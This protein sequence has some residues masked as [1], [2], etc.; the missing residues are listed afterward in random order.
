MNIPSISPVIVKHHIK[1]DGSVNVKIRITHQRKTRYLPTNE[2]AYKGDYTKDC[3][4]K[5]LQILGRMAKLV[6]KIQGAIKG[7][8]MFEVSSMDVDKLVL[9]IEAELKAQEE[10]H[11][12][13][14]HFGEQVAASKPKYSGANYRTALNSFSRFLGKDY[15]DISEISSSLMRSFESHLVNKHGKDARAVSL[16]ISALAS[17]HTEARRRYNNEEM[18]EMKIRNP[19]EFY[20]PPKQKPAKKRTLEP[21][22]I[23]KLINIRGSLS[24]LHK[25]AVDVFLLS[26]CL[27]GTNVPDLY[28][29]EID[30]DVIYYNRMKT[31]SRRNDNAEMQIRM[32]PVC[33]CIFDDMLDPSCQ[34]AFKLHNQYTFYKS[35]SDK[36]NDRLKEVA[37]LIGEKPFTMYAARHTWATV[38][39][40]IGIPKSLINDCLCHVDPNMS[41]TDIYIKKDWSVLWEANR[42]V[43]EKFNWK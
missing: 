28:E 16:Y 31:R 6:E 40:S 36:A 20:T 11:L 5:N 41:V 8:D 30:G 35:I 33:Q 22:T 38:A 1:K 2:I 15:I 4:I 26:F 10:F 19:F 32:E 24:D 25:L 12:D 23:Q 17:I 39:Y 13:F 27:M 29:A 37:T 43:L 14:F 34:R 7:M 3:T 21:E 42:K 9:R 18:D